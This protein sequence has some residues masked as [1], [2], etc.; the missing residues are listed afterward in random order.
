MDLRFPELLLRDFGDADPHNSIS[1]LA[2]LKVMEQQQAVTLGTSS[3]TPPQ[4]MD[5]L[6]RTKKCA[7]KT[8]FPNSE[9]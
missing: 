6:L 5:V 8:I 2:F 1:L 7:N 3:A 9:A 4:A